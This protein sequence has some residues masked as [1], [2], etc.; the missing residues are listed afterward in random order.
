[1][2][3]LFGGTGGLKVYVGSRVVVVFFVG[4]GGLRVWGLWGFFGF[5]SIPKFS[6]GFGVKVSNFSQTS[7]GSAVHPAHGLLLSGLAD[8][9]V[10]S[11]KGLGLVRSYRTT[12]MSVCNYC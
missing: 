8:L 5:L 2:R 3:L 11:S 1:M 6:Q 12:P 10:E 4:W 9:H 7:T